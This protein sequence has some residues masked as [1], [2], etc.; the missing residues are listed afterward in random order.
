MALIYCADFPPRQAP[1]ADTATLG[2][3]ADALEPPQWKVGDRWAVETVTQR[4]QGREPLT[5]GKLPR[6]RW[7]FQVSRIEP[8][9]GHDCYRIDIQCQA[10]GRQQPKSTVWCDKQTQF[11]RRFQTQLAVD[12]QYR[13]IA[14]S[15]DTAGG[16]TSPVLASFNV[17]PLAMPAFVAKGSKSAGTFTYK[18]QP[19]VSSKDISVV[20]FAHAVSQEVVPPGSKALEEMP[21]GIAKELKDKQVTEVRLSD[22]RQKVMQL[23]QKG[24]PWPVYADNGRTKAWL[25]R[26]KKD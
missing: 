11:L 26:E 22:R 9:D 18:S 10:G 2:P 25:V 7:E 15:Y 8:I 6:V 12:G 20:R 16:Q 13:T 21:E 4:I 23:W 5:A 17:L 14:E 3:S 24:A 1:A 19:V